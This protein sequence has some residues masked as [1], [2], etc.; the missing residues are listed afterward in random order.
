MYESVPALRLNDVEVRFQNFSGA[1]DKYNS[2]GGKRQFNIYFTNEELGEQL[3]AD[4]WGVKKEI[5]DDPSY[6]VRYRMVVK[7]KMDGKRPPIIKRQIEGHDFDDYMLL[8][9]GN[10]GQLDMDDIIS[11]NIEVRGNGWEEGISPWL[12]KGR[13]IVADN[14]I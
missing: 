13:F 1:P 3:I 7:V 6:P 5:P 4:G 12:N 9:E 10:I 8:D 11:A 2:N 14:D